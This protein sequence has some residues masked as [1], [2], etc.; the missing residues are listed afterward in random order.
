MSRR[1]GRRGCRSPSWR[2]RS[3]SACA[4]IAK[5]GIDVDDHPNLAAAKQLA[6]S[7]DIQLAISNPCF[8]LWGLLHFA[9]Q[10]GHIERHKLRVELQKHLPGYDK[11]LAFARLDPGY[12]EAVRRARDLEAA[13][14]RD[15]RV[16]G[17][18][19]TGVHVLTELIRTH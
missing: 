4:P 12:D 15:D 3:P 6:L 1:W 18:P 16:G 11:E 5:R 9:D 2:P 13:A 14:S 19:T 10:R 8:E 17:N 7:N